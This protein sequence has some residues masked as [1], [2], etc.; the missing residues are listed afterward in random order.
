[1]ALYGV[2]GIGGGATQAPMEGP[3]LVFTGPDAGSAWF[4]GE[5]QFRWYGWRLTE[6]NNARVTQAPNLPLAIRV[7]L[8]TFIP[9]KEM[10]ALQ[11]V[12]RSSVW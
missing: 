2:Q 9:G 6:L 1:M 4:G 3:R 7:A 10:T 5:D 8:T 11:A 12:N